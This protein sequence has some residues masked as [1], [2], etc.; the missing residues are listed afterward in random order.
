MSERRCP[1]CQAAVENNV[2][3]SGHCLI[4]GH[5]LIMHRSPTIV[6]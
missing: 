6:D 2:S 5:D 4:C 1:A 3:S